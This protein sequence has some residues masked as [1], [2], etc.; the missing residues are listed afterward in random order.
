MAAGRLGKSL[1]DYYLC[2]SI[3]AN[4]VHIKKKIISRNYFC[5]GS[6]SLFHEESNRKLA[7]QPSRRHL[8]VH[9]YIAIDILRNE[10]ITVPNGGV[11]RT[12]DEALSIAESLESEDYVIK[13]QV[14][15]GGRGKGHFDGGLKGG[16][17]ILFSPEEVQ[18]IASKMLGKNLYTLQT[19]TVG[20]PCNE[21]LIV[22]RLFPRREY[23]F[24][25]T[26]DRS[27][28]GPLLIGSSQ[29]G[30]SIEDVAK[31]NPDAIVK[32]PVDIFDGLNRETAVDFA[33]RVGFTGTSILG[34]SELFM[35]LYNL[36]LKKDCTLIEINPFSE[37]NSGTVCCMDCK[38]SFDDN[39]LFRHQAILEL[40]DWTQEDTREVQATKHD[41]N[42]IGL[43]GSIGWLNFIF[44]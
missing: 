33:N 13:A 32:Q 37:L 31:E 18:D 28:R 26:L 36:F 19:G 38:I 5:L 12:P 6:L 2:F 29:G 39:A 16:V 27:A 8:S 42:Y 9:E 41:L 3:G 34:A 21:V 24:G 20:R 22:E 43:D 15:A 10:G 14:L 1:K 7:N 4:N 17:K 40:K 44:E 23:Y 30:M 35:K 11:A 25:I